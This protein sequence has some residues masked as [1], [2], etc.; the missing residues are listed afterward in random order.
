MGARLNNVCL[1]SDRTVT[2]HTIVKPMDDPQMETDKLIKVLVIDDHTLTCEL[3]C[4]FLHIEGGFDCAHADSVE[5]AVELIQKTGPFD[6]VLLDLEMPG[7]N[8][9]SGIERFITLSKPGY[10][11]LFSGSARIEVA[12]RA[13]EA[14]VRGF[15]PK[16]LP[17]KSLC[18]AVRFVAAGETYLPQAFALAFAK[19]ERKKRST[20]I[21]TAE[22][23]VLKGIC[24]G[25][26]NK[27][28]A[29]ELGLSEI[30]VKMHVRSICSK[31]S[32]SNRTQIAMT[33][34]AQGLI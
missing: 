10:V 34:I 11:I 31:L 19:P 3:T 17:V 12:L 30:T 5:R 8:G 24:K 15:I 28:I 16:T 13:I 4:S 25:Q 7:M 32:V 9:M 22:K 26:T 2:K 29:R 21:S 23:D 27:D 14:G 33:A 6:I 20:T 1:N 18:N